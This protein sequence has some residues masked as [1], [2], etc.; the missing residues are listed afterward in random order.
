[1]QAAEI[2][3]LDDGTYKVPAGSI[4]E[5]GTYFYVKYAKNAAIADESPIN[6][7]ETVSL[8]GSPYSWRVNDNLKADGSINTAD[9]LYTDIVTRQDGRRVFFETQDAGQTD[10][11]CKDVRYYLNVS[12]DYYVYRLTDNPENRF[13]KIT[14][15]EVEPGMRVWYGLRNSVITFIIVK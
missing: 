15:N 12:G 5:E 2:N 7:V 3:I 1:M 9:G 11:L 6:V 4:T 14:V 8:D 10:E 13:E